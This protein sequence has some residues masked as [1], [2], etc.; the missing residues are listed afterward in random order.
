MRFAAATAA[1]DSVIAV[2][3]VI[4]IIATADVDADAATIATIVMSSRVLLKIRDLD[5][6]R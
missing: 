2:V 3:V 5:S 4:I 1:T 6:L